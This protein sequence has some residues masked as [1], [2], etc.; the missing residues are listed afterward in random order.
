MAIQT[1]KHL[2]PGFEDWWKPY[3]DKMAV[4]PLMRYFNQTRTDILHE[5][6]LQ[7]TNYTVVGR[8]GPVDIG[9]LMRELNQHAPPNTIG[10]FLGD[11][12]GGN[13][14]E[15]RMPD[16]TTEKVY[17][18]LP[19]ELDIESGLQLPNPPTEHYGQPITDTSLA[20]VGHLYVTTLAAVVDEFVARFSGFFE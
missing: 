1:M 4:D 7:T 17:F 11:Q 5:G 20:N 9:Q 13:G 14:W 8:R 3:Q 19:A 6:E 16:G 18:Q 15:V 12:Y 10:T 2:D